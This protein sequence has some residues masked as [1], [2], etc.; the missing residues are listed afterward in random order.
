MKEII[1]LINSKN[2]S[3]EVYNIVKENASNIR[4][5]DSLIEEIADIYLSKKQSYEKVPISKKQAFA[6]INGIFNKTERMPKTKKTK[7]ESSHSTSDK[8]ISEPL[9]TSDINEFIRKNLDKSKNIS[10]IRFIIDKYNFNTNNVI[11]YL[12]EFELLLNIIHYM[13]KRRFP[14]NVKDFNNSKNYIESLIFYLREEKINSGLI[15]NTGYAKK[16]NINQVLI[17][18]GIPQSIKIPNLIT[19]NII[20]D[21]S[22]KRKIEEVTEL[23]KNNFENF[24]EL[25]EVSFMKKKI[26]MHD[27]IRIKIENTTPYQ[28]V[29]G[30]PVNRKITEN[31]LNFYTKENIEKCKKYINYGRLKFTDYNESEEV[32]PYSISQVPYC[33]LCGNPIVFKY[34][35]KKMDKFINC[36]IDHIVPPISAYVLG[37]IQCPL[38]FMPVHTKCNLSKTNGFPSIEGIDSTQNNNILTQDNLE[39]INIES[40][41]V[42]V[43]GG[44]TFKNI[45]NLIKN[46]KYGGSI[47]ESFKNF[48]NKDI[49]TAE[50]F[51]NAVF[52]ENIDKWSLVD[53]VKFLK[54]RYLL[55]N[56]YSKLVYTD[57]EI[58]D[59]Y[60]EALIVS[61]A[62]SK[63][64]LK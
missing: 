39:G 31:L 22:K 54:E 29:N 42:P 2:S 57:Q 19:N 44:S 40:T 28:Y 26:S 45:I 23:Y 9:D 56:E 1:K 35:G 55:L 41:N 4:V 51:G 14:L 43:M 6:I 38:N 10:R 34:N 59:R 61:D 63:H 7:K 33:Y 64:V 21:S 49:N 36:S 32:H 11:E 30:D 25:K 48:L 58:E 53:R 47:D 24:F 46:K 52:N 13:N 20:S 17:E 12:F 60:N 62:I 15:N 27:Y 3:I 8:E 5:S 18:T 37:I 50:L 16:I